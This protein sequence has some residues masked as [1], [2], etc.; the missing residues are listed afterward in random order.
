MQDLV[1]YNTQKKKKINYIY[2]DA[3][4]CRIAVDTHN[5]HVE[6]EYSPLNPNNEFDSFRRRTKASATGTTQF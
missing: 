1:V 3:R 2:N 4:T 5:P 6:H